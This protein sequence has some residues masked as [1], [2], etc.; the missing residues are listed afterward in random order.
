M[1]RAYG[2][3]CGEPS[4]VNAGTMYTPSLPSSERASPSV[5]AA[6]SITPSASRSHCTAAP[7]TKIAAS[8]A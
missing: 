3:Q 1:P 2:S 6:A 4:P 8:S 7:V 5:S